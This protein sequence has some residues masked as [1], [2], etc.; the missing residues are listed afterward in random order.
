MDRAT[1]A[2]FKTIESAKPRIKADRIE[3]HDLIDDREE[4]GLW[5]LDHSTRA[6]R[7]RP[8]RPDDNWTG[9]LKSHLILIKTQTIE[10][11]AVRADILGRFATDSDDFALSVFALRDWVDLASE[12]NA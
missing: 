11:L 2:R 7:V 8:V 10:R 6:F 5:A 1:C 3:L 4:H 12:G 9:P